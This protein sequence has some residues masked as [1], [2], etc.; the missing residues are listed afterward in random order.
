MTPSALATSL[1]S[2]ADFWMLT[3]S[4]LLIFLLGGAFAVLSLLAYRRNGKRSL[5]AA[6]LGFA[7]ISVGFIFEWTYEFGVKGG[8]FFTQTELARV[9][10]VE[11]LLLFA[12]FALLLFSVY[13]S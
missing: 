7:F 3:L 8:L 4:R 9:Q 11:G 1:V 10:T 2:S 13:R 5:L 12:G 6:I